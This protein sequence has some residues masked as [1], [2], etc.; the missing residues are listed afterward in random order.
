MKSMTSSQTP[1]IYVLVDPA[2]RAT[3]SICHLPFFRHTHQSRRQFD[4]QVFEL[5]LVPQTA[6]ARN[7]NE[8][9][10]YAPHPLVLSHNLP[11]GDSYMKMQGTTGLFLNDRYIMKLFMLAKL[12]TK[13]L[14]VF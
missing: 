13:C 11:S 1:C 3:S 8:L 6:L 12:S 9:R 10:F 5:S 7:L 14:P 2:R 4:L